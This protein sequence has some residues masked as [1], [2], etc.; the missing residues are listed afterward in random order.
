MYI[1]CIYLYRL[2]GVTG[3]KWYALAVPEAQTSY[4]INVKNTVLINHSY[5]ENAQ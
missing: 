3:E 2:L 5:G 4:T 1:I